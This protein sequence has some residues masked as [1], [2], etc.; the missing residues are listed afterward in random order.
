MFPDLTRDD[1]FRLETKRLWL[2]WPCAADAGAIVRLAGDR[3][4][5][6]MTARIPHPL[7]R[8]TVDAFILDARR[9]NAEG[10]GLVMG[11]A[12]RGRPQ[13]LVGIVSVEH[14]PE[15][16]GPHL[17][18]WLGA[19]HWGQGLATEA[20]SSLVEATF[21]FTHA[22]VLTSAARVEN[23][24]SRRVL[25]K[26]GF[27]REDTACLPF[28]ARGASLPVDRVRLRRRDW[29]RRHA[30]RAADLLAVHV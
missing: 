22:A 1:V 19:P 20:V 2:R 28:P 24:A 3:A 10:H 5:A 12:L 4:V 15:A 9:T 7:D 23:T 27:V 11:L 29:E 30:R 16:A 26:C 21:A 13:A 18:Y 25:T 6:E 17:G 8:S 14:D